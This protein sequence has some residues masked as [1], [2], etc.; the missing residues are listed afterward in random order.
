MFFHGGNFHGDYVSLEMDKVKIAITRLCM[1]MERQLNFLL[2]DHLNQILPPFVNGGKL[3][4]NFGL[5]GAQFTATST[6][7]E[8]QTLSNPM[9]VHSIPCNK[10]NQDIVSM[11]TN[12]AL[13]T[14]RVIENTYIVMAIHLMAINTAIEYLGIEEKL[15]PATR[16]CY[17]ELIVVLP[18]VKEDK[19]LSG[20][21]NSSVDFLKNMTL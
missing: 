5:Q 13:M 19:P 21:I 1:L 12:A 8:N 9:Y 16:Q 18:P 6:T 2:N 3:G 14:R 15:A 10:D 17:R 20:I 7:A 11:G 4:F